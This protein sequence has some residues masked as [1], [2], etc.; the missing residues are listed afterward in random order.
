MT[1]LLIEA[2][3][4]EQDRPSGVNYLT[5]GLV[6]ELEKQ[7]NDTFSVSYF[8]LN[9]LGHKTLRNKN[10]T[11]AAMRGDLQQ[12]QTIPQR[13]Y[14]KLVYYRI[15]PPLPVR[16]ADWLLYPNF[17]LWPTFGRSKKAV[18]IHDLCYLRYPE[19]VED[20]NRAFLARVAT[21]SIKKAD[22]V[23][24]DSKFIADEVV[25]LTNTPREKVHIL[26]VPVDASEF[27]PAKNLGRDRLAKRYGITKPYILT[28]GTLEPRKNLTTLVEAYCALTPE[29]RNT[30]SLVLAGKWGWKI[31]DLRNLVEQ[32]QA[33]GYDIIT[34]DYVDH[35]DRTA[36]YRNASFYAITTHY[37]GFGMPLLEALHCGIPTVAV[38]IPVLREVGGDACLWA[39]KTTQD[40]TSKLTQLITD[41][42]LSAKLSALG[43]AQSAKFSW[44]VTAK[45]LIQHLQ[46]TA[47]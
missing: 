47:N 6:T 39:E 24:V 28:F 21:N 12:I 11:A 29:I 43:P 35:G 8:W 18:I 25:E 4:L 34:T 9:F 7:Q 10:T 38:D 37:E 15:A 26:G 32:K 36:F 5:D 30:Y 22:L 2:S 44:E 23:L 46:Y 14:A 45:E 13:L 16:K 3:V 41:K 42:T 19:Y 20:K 17:Y 33:D 31:D 1:K 40:V 27:D